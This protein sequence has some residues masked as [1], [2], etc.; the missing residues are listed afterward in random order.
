MALVQAACKL[1]G[2]APEGVLD[3]VPPGTP[4][5]TPPAASE[6]QALETEAT[7]AEAVEPEHAPEHQHAE[8]AP[9]G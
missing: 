9:P 1:T 7:E 8:H 2:A 5:V 6:P 4:T 3:V